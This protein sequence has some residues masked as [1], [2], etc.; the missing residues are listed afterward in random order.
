[1]LLL[2]SPLS[3]VFKTFLPL[4][5]KLIKIPE[6]C[7]L[8][9]GRPQGQ[10]LKAAKYSLVC[11]HRIITTKSVIIIILIITIIIIIINNVII[12][13]I[14]NHYH[15]H[16]III[17]TC[18][19]DICRFEILR[20]LKVFASNC[21]TAELFTYTCT[22]NLHHLHHRHCHWHQHQHHHPIQM[23]S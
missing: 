5:E 22:N 20:P 14:L 4:K 13:I 1:M 6:V 21:L 2:E 7:L 18:A 8:A 23:S 9:R 17:T 19:C 3:F 11:H 12:V 16:T 15:R 10:F